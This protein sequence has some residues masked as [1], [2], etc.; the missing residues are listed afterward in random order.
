M[1]QEPIARG[2][3]DQCG[4]IF[5]FNAS[6]IKIWFRSRPL[7]PEAVFNCPSCNSIMSEEISFKNAY[8]FSNMGCSIRHSYDEKKDLQPFSE[9][10]IVDFIN[11]TDNLDFWSKINE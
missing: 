5:I 2:E 11:Q 8:L 7:K 6:Q 3:C 9:Q 10:D 1:S 4:P